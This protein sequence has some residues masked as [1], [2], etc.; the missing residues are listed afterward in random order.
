MKRFNCKTCWTAVLLFAILWLGWGLLSGTAVS[1][2]SSYPTADDLFV[3]DYADVINS[4]DEAQIRELLA[5][6]EAGSGVQMTVLTVRSF[7]DYNT[8][9]TTIEQF[10]TNLFNEWGIGQASRNDGVLFL[11]AIEDRELRVELGAAY[12][13]EFNGRMQRIIDQIIIPY[14]R[15][16]KYSLGI[17]EGSRAIIADLRGE[18]YE[19]LAETRGGT[20]S[21]PVSPPAT[22]SSETSSTAVRYPTIFYRLEEIL[23][24]LGVVGTPLGALLFARYR[25]NRPRQCT[26]CQTMMTRL[27]ERADDAYLDKGQLSEEHLGSVDYDVWLCGNCQQREVIPYKN[28]LRRYDR[29]RN[30]NYRTVSNSSKVISSATY[31]STGLRENRAYC[32]H[33]HHEEITQSVIPR[34]VKSSS[35][36]SSFGSSSRSSSSFGGGRSSGG[37]ASGKW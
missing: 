29:C 34:K 24:G 36:S 33:C 5:A 3:N 32:N 25:R 14:F 8:G 31:T 11:V 7:T 9:D 26:N 6:Y 12:G 17:H 23:I 35:S 15:Q 37:G 20:S 1:A 4:T 30:C 10:A 22:S 21:S 28:W 19:S 16:E 27:D 2:Q 18:V 13:V